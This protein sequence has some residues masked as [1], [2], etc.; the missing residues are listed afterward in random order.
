MLTNNS[1]QSDIVTHKTNAEIKES[2]S[3]RL[4]TTL[5]YIDE[6]IKFC[7]MASEWR[8]PLRQ[9]HPVQRRGPVQLAQHD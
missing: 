5:A 8:Q 2:T 7:N 6:E 3:N 4:F 9:G 1:D